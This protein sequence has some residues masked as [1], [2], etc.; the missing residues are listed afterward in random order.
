MIDGYRA[1][2]ALTSLALSFL[3]TGVTI[4]PHNPCRLDPSLYSARAIRR[5]RTLLQLRMLELR[6]ARLE[7]VRA[8][9]ERRLPVDALLRSE[10]GRRPRSGRPH[11][12]LKQK[13]PNTTT[14]CQE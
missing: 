6:E 14:L 11:R 3:L 1:R 5:A 12:P 4:E 7:R 13:R 10:P 8:V 9:I 2:V